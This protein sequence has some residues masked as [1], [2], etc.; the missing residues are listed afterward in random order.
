MHA[1]HIATDRHGT[2]LYGGLQLGG[3]N[4][5]P[6]TDVNTAAY[7]SASMAEILDGKVKKPD[8]VLSLTS[9]IDA[10]R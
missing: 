8:G 6:A 5:S 10:M 3:L 4:Y 7:G 9:A 1:A 2:I